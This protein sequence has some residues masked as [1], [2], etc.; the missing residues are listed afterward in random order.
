MYRRNLRKVRINT[1][2]EENK[3][4]RYGGKKGLKEV[5]FEKTQKNKEKLIVL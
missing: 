4:R 1:I 5:G 2:D 3:K